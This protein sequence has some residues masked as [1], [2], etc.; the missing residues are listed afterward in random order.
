MSPQVACVIPE[1]AGSA[2]HTWAVSVWPVH[3]PESACLSRITPG[4]LRSDGSRDDWH[5]LCHLVRS[6][7]RPTR[8]AKIHLGFRG[9]RHQ[10]GQLRFSPHYP[11]RR[12]APGSSYGFCSSYF[13]STT[14][15]FVGSP[16]LYRKE[17]PRSRAPNYNDKRGQ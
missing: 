6:R 12:T 7:V 9:F 4:R 15:T 5:I 1:F 8:Q 2:T 14:T 17:N 16:P 13:W 10:P 3:G 11:P